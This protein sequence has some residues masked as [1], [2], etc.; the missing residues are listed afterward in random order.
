[1]LLDENAQHTGIQIVSG[2]AVKPGEFQKK[3]ADGEERPWEGSRRG[4]LEF[5]V[6]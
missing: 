6:N 2:L 1:L 4:R 3:E 5:F